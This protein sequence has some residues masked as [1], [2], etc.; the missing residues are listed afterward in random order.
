MFRSFRKGAS[1]AALHARR[2]DDEAT[3]DPAIYGRINQLVRAR[4]D[5]VINNS[6]GGGIN[7]DMVRQMANGLWEII[8]EERLKG[9]EAG[10]EIATLDAH[11]AVA[12]FAGREIVVATTP[13]RCEEMATLFQLQAWGGING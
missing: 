5:I 12:T 13:Q 11:T 6:T 1:V 4:C 7:G 10:C 9:I 8:Y 3:C 2:R